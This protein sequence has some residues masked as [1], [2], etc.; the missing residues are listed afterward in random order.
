MLCSVNVQ[1]LINVVNVH[2]TLCH[3]VKVVSFKNELCYLPFC[4]SIEKW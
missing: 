3:L 4:L 2:S 1:V